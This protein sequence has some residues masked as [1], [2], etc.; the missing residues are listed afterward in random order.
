[1]VYS[2]H[3]EKMDTKEATNILLE[4][5]SGGKSG[6]KRPEGLDDETLLRAMQIESE[7]SSNHIIQAKIVFDHVTEHPDYYDKEYG[8]GEWEKNLK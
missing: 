3:E 7:H 1:L 4:F 6:G 8:L 2:K 5:L